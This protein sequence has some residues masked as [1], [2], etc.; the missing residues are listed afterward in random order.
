MTRHW[1]RAR[2]LSSTFAR[3]T[4]ATSSTLWPEPANERQCQISMR[5]GLGLGDAVSVARAH[6]CFRKTT[7]GFLGQFHANPPRSAGLA[8][9]H[10][11]VEAVAA[12]NPAHHV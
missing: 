12:A 10:R 7:A 6:A 9:R 11:V 3:K 2:T 4:S 5:G 1:S 8:A